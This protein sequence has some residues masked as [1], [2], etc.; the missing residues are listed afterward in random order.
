MFAFLGAVSGPRHALIYADELA[1]EPAEACTPVIAQARGCSTAIH[2]V[3]RP[4]AAFPHGRLLAER[5][6]GTFLPIGSIDELGSAC[7]KLFVALFHPYE[8]TYAAREQAVSEIK[9]EAYSVDSRG[10]DVLRV[11]PS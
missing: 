9:L 11:E 1:G 3:S 8:I 10:S 2:C 7:E 6:T 4:G 5:T